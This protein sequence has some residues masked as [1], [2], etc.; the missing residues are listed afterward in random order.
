MCQ[1]RAGKPDDAI[2][3]FI[4]LEVNPAKVVALYPEHVA[5]RLSV[6]QKEWL[7]LFGGPTTPPSPDGES[8]QQA[9]SA[10]QNVQELLVTSPTSTVLG[11]LKG[12]ATATPPIAEKD[13]DAASTGSATKRQATRGKSTFLC[14]CA[15]RRSFGGFF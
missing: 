4:D 11:K 8:G 2:N 3:E 10:V 12:L 15:T 7:P 14:M 1:F 13:D 6:P 5:G 9:T